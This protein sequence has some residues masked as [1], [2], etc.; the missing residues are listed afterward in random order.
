MIDSA[1]L[2][3]YKTAVFTEKAREDFPFD[4]L[5]AAP[6]RV[7]FFTRIRLSG[8]DMFEDVYTCWRDMNESEFIGRFLACTLMDFAP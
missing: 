5:P 3:P 2:R 7:K 8:Q 4:N 1:T 6:V